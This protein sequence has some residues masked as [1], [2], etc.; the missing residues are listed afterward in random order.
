MAVTPVSVPNSFSPSTVAQ[1]SQ[2]NANFTALLNAF[3]TG[4]MGFNGA[5]TGHLYLPGGFLVQW[6]KAATVAADGSAATAVTYD[7]TFPT[8]LWGV[9]TGIS[10]AYQSNPWA[11]TTQTTAETSTGFNL[12]VAGA[13]AASTVNVWWIAIG[14]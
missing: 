9:V 14:N 5:A 1:S 7:V 8:N 11:L 2:V 10:N 6:G 4:T 13:P 12:N 3:N